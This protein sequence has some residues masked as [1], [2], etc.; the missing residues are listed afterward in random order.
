MK[1][2][3]KEEQELME[4]FEK[5]EWR[6]LKKKEQKIFVKAAKESIAKS[7]RV[8]ILLTPQDFHAIQTKALEEGI[9]FQTLIASIVHKYNKGKLKRAS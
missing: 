3:N 2:T 1:F 6:S 4:S 9:P 7:K 8:Q 5:G